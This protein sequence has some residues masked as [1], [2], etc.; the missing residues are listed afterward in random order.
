MLYSTREYAPTLE[1]HGWE[2]CVARARALVWERRWDELGSIVTDEMLDQAVPAA[3]YDDLAAVYRDRYAGLADAVT[4][5]L[6]DDPAD[7]VRIAR[8]VDAVRQ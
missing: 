8:V 5:P 3:V 7:D 1:L 2:E 4:L 6:P